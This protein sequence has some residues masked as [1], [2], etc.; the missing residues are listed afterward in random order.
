MSRLRASLALTSTVM[1]TSSL[2][3]AWDSVTRPG[4]RNQPSTTNTFPSGSPAGKFRAS[5]LKDSIGGRLPDGSDD[6]S[7]NNLLVCSAALAGSRD[8][9]ASLH[10]TETQKAQELA[11]SGLH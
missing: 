5:V 4:V 2:A 9:G 11:L 6:T 7:V 3:P 8:E 10:G 1:L